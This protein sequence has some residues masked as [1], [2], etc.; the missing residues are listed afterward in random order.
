MP[1]YTFENTDTGEVFDEMMSISA[2]EQ[3]LADN[4]HLQ[5]VYNKVNFAG[6]VGGVKTD[7]LFKDEVLGRIGDHH[8]G[9]EMHDRYGKKTIKEVKTKQAIDK[10]RKKRSAD[11]NK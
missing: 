3:Y 9:T 6:M 7:D 8:V 5:Q 4:P 1:I 11:P 2:R 10:W